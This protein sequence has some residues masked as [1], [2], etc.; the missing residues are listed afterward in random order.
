VVSDIRF[1]YYARSRAFGKWLIT[2]NSLVS[3]ALWQ[4]AYGKIL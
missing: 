4:M 3:L 1:T 2:D